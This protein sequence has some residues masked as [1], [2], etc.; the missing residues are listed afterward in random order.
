[1]EAVTYVTRSPEHRPLRSWRSCPHSSLISA[2]TRRNGAVVVVGYLWSR[3]RRSG[4]GGSRPSR[5]SALDFLC[6]LSGETDRALRLLEASNRSGSALLVAQTF[7][8]IF[9]I[10]SSG[11][12]RIHG[13][14]LSHALPK[15]LTIGMTHPDDRAGRS[16]Q[17]IPC[18]A[19][20]TPS[21]V[22]HDACRT[23]LTSVI[24]QGR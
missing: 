14:H 17:R 13:V 6:G 24:D 11:I 23:P 12:G 5:M 19:P 20:G 9:F 3:A 2:R 4:G 8:F 22:T 10:H 1:M 16:L 21:Q 18:T 15:R 7:S